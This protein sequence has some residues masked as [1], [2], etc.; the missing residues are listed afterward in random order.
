MIV[1]DTHALVW[2][3]QDDAALGSEA[4]TIIQA[5]WEFG[6]VAVSAIVFWECQMLHN[7]GRLKLGM[8]VTEWRSDWLAAGLTEIPVDGD[9]ALASIRLDLPHKDPADRFITATA[10]QRGGALVTADRTLLQW[11][12]ALPRHDAAR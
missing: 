2:L 8:P 6:E 7:A 1:L 4:R 10:I 3:D 5:A 12:N 11:D 9:I